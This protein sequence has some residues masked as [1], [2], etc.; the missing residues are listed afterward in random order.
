MLKNLLLL[1]LMIF[2][3]AH[4]S[5]AAPQVS[6]QQCVQKYNFN[7]LAL[8]SQLVILENEIAKENMIK[9]VADTEQ[10][11]DYFTR[12]QYGS[13][14]IGAGIGAAAGS[15]LIKRI[16]GKPLFGSVGGSALLSNSGYQSIELLGFNGF[17][18]LLIGEDNK[19]LLQTSQEEIEKYLINYSQDMALIFNLDEAKTEALQN[20]VRNLFLEL[21]LEVLKGNNVEFQ[22]DIFEIL[23][24]IDHQNPIAM[25]F[26]ARDINSSLGQS[27]QDLD[28]TLS[29]LINLTKQIRMEL[30]DGARPELNTVIVKAVRE[31]L[32]ARQLCEL[33]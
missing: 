18:S 14:I 30:P 33:L 23:E 17:Q 6:E 2:F 32:E 22:L 13:T 28:D 26:R 4:Q 3:S 20:T 19:S 9:I 25:N 21:Y 16:Y 1:L 24:S 29:A 5:I 7:I 8:S 27:L 31:R 11:Q 15:F 12:F 10:L